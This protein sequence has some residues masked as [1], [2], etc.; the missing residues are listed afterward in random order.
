MLDFRVDDDD[1]D[2]VPFLI[3][4]TVLGLYARTSGRAGL[5]FG[6]YFGRRPT[7]TAILV[8]IEQFR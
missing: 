2:G 6:T 3:L 8:V 4:V 1:D 7:T 5:H